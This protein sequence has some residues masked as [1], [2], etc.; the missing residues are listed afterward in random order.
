MQAENFLDIVGSSIG[1]WILLCF[2][3]GFAGGFCR[4]LRTDF[5]FDIKYLTQQRTHSVEGVGGFSMFF[6]EGMIL[7]D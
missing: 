4:S 1:V 2:C 7:S 3:E 5:L 6:C